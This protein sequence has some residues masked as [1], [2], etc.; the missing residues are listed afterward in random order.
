MSTNQSQSNQNPPNP[1]NQNPPKANYSVYMRL[2][3]V[4]SLL[5][6]M[7]ITKSGRGQYNYLQLEDFL[8]DLHELCDEYGICPCLEF[9]GEFARLVIVNVDEPHDIVVFTSPVV[10]AQLAGKTKDPLKELGATQSYI[11][12]YLFLQAFEISVP[13][14]VDANQSVAPRETIADLGVI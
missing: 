2:Q 1:E 12:R 5:A 8:P 11:R 13:C 9:T 4:R 3:A 14:E 10:G 7:D 6:M